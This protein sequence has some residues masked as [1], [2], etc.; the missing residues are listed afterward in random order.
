MAY[1]LRACLSICSANRVFFGDI[2]FL[3]P[4]SNS[5]FK[6]RPFAFRPFLERFVYY[7]LLRRNKC[8]KVQKLR[9]VSQ[10]RFSLARRKS[11]SRITT[12]R[13]VQIFD[14]TIA[15][16]PFS[17]VRL[18]HRPKVKNKEEMTPFSTIPLTNN[19]TIIIVIKRTRRPGQRRADKLEPTKPRIRVE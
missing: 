6:N 10:T 2:F 8:S 5:T 7:F 13:R 19:N 15:F 14:I 1:T 16:G 17:N 3:L 18:A 9:G 12:G 4:T 11:I